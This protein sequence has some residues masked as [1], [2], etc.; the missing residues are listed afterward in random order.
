LD[1]RRFRADL[2]ELV[3]RACSGDGQEVRSQVFGL[4]DVL[5]GLYRKNFVKINHSALELVCARGLVKQ[6]YDVNG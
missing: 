4:A 3:T 5:D 1:V 6:G 2:C